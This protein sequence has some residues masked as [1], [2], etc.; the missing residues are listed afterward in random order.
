MRLVMRSDD[1]R[2]QVLDEEATEEKQEKADAE[3]AKEEG[4]E[5]SAEPVDPVMKSVGNEVWDWRVQND[6]K[7]LWTRPP[8]EARIPAAPYATCC[9]AA[10]KSLAAFG[11]VF[12]S[13]LPRLEG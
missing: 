2:G 7:P 1:A 6:N 3:A 5:G 11:T 4:K 13:V 9:R 12:F 8:K 10:C